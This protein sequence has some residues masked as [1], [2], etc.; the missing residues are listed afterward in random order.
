MDVKTWWNSTLELLDQA[1][2]LQD[3]TH[4]WLKN[5]KFRDYRQLFIT[6]DEWTIV[7]YVMDV[8]WT[9]RDWSLWMLQ[10]HNVTLSHVITVKNDMFNHMDGVMGGLAK[11]QIQWK[12]GLCFAVMFMQ[13]KLS[14]SHSE[15]TS[16]TGMRLISAH[17]LDPFQKLRL[18]MKWGKGMVNNP[19]DETSSTS[20]YQRTFL[21]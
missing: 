15:V 18:L 20:Q 2:Q 19:E 12:E 1:L 21:K 4:E 7:K 8:L 9:F 10:W 11:K 17:I 14:K 16:M 3:F 6:Q 13:Q 5:R